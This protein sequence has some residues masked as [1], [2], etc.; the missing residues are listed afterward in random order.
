[1]RRDA[2]KFEEWYKK[3]HKEEV[4]K[5]DLSNNL[6]RQIKGMYKEAYVAGHKEASN[7]E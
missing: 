5:S 3:N 6:K 2:K 4:E 1:M 7:K